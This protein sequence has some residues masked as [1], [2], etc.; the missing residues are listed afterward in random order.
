MQWVTIRVLAVRAILVKAILVKDNPGQGN[1]G[2]GNPGQGNP[3]QGNPGQGNPGQGNP[4]QGNP[5]QGN[6]GKGNLVK[7]IPVKILAKAIRTPTKVG[8]EMKMTYRL[9]IA[10]ALILFLTTPALAADQSAPQTTAQ[11][12]EAIP[13]RVQKNKVRLLRA[14]PPKATFRT[15][16]PPEQTTIHQPAQRNRVQLLLD[17][18]QQPDNLRP[19]VTP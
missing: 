8:K 5:G 10:A 15:N 13:R 7:A 17:Q 19:A 14:L 4:G 9:S 18:R 11:R 3:G 6:P 12:R 2:Q 1:P 16:P